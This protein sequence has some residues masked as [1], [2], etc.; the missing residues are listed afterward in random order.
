M[1]QKC[2]KE[3]IFPSVIGSHTYPK[4]MTESGDIVEILQRILKSDRLECLR[5]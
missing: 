1:G 5:D 2:F 3:D 4:R